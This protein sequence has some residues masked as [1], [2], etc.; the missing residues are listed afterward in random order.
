MIL[1]WKDPEGKT[2]STLTNKSQM[3]AAT[4]GTEVKKI[5]SLE[6]A[7]C[8]RDNTIVQ[9]KQEVNVLKGIHQVSTNF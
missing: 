1:L 6:K 2:I 5:A 3:N 9:L 7:L 8:E 4:P